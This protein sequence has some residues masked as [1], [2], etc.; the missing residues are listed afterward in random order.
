MTAIHRRAMFRGW[1][2]SPDVGSTNQ[3]GDEIIREYLRASAPPHRVRSAGVNPSLALARA[4]A[5]QSSPMPT[6]K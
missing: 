5:R 3:A 6:I 4:G 2:G 1:R